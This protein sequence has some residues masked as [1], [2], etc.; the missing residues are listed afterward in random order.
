MP[1]LSVVTKR[2]LQ[3][4]IDFGHILEV[5]HGNKIASKFSDL[6]TAHLVIAKQLVVAPKTGDN[7]AASKDEE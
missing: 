1:D 7:Q 5:C 6:L 3:N 2:L 4:P